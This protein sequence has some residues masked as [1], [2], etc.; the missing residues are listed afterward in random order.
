MDEDSLRKYVG[1]HIGGVIFAEYG[2]D[3]KA[4]FMYYSHLRLIWRRHPTVRSRLGIMTGCR[5]A[6]VWYFTTSACHICVYPTLT[7]LQGRVVQA[8]HHKDI[9][10]VSYS[11]GKRHKFSDNSTFLHPHICSADK[12]C[13]GSHS[14]LHSEGTTVV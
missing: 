7:S 11:D 14:S 4:S 9:F 13:R 3:I 1:M 10:L 5:V 2:A 8:N 6:G 12:P